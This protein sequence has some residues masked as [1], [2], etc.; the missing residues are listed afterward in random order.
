MAA[1]KVKPS[2]TAADR[3]LRL[4]RI[5][6]APCAVLFKV[7]TQPE[8]LARWTAP[9][10][11]TVPVCEG[12]LTPG[13]AWRSCLRMPDGTELWLSGV[14]RAIVPDRLLVFTHAWVEDGRR[15]PETLVTVKFAALGAKTKLTFTQGPFAAAESLHGHQGGWSECFEKLAELLAELKPRKKIYV[16]AKR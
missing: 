8:H 7:W 14:Y 13:G 11:F 2:P 15:G 5:F 12:E 4:T 3:T 16:A 6:D 10:G 9:R 1:K